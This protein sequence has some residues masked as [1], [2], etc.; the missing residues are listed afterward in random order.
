[1][2]MQH[3]GEDALAEVSARMHHWKTKTFGQL[4]VYHMKPRNGAAGGLLRRHWQMGIRDY[5]LHN[6]P[7]FEMAKCVYRVF[8]W[9]FGIGSLVRCAA[10]FSQ[11]LRGA[12]R[13][14]PKELVKY[15]RAEQMRKVFPF[16]QSTVPPIHPHSGSS[17]PNNARSMHSHRGSIEK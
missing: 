9:P 1:M 4:T 2:P 15:L 5:G 8:E 12:H 6:Q 17:Q 11:I 13:D 10:Y 3:G 16:F 14:V 7:L